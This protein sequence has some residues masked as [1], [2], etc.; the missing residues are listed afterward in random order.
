MI[1]NDRGLDFERIR[2]GLMVDYPRAADLPAAGF[3]A[4]P[5]LLKDTMQLAAAWRWPPPPGTWR[6]ASR[7]AGRWPRA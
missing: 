1:A 5:C 2:Q 6:A 4:G 3:A 7:W